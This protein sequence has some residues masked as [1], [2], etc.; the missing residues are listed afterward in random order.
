[1]YQCCRVIW[2]RFWHERNLDGKLT[3]TVTLGTSAR[4]RQRKCGSYSY[5]VEM[6]ETKYNVYFAADP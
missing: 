1:M 4:Y 2:A 5:H 6:F 3:L